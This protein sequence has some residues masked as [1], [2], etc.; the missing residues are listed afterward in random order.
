MIWYNLQLNIADFRSQF[1]SQIFLTFY[2]CIFDS[3]IHPSSFVSLSLL[4][5]C[6][7][8]ISSLWSLNQNRVSIFYSSL[9]CLFLLETSHSNHSLLDT[10]SLTWNFL[11]RSLEYI[12]LSVLP[13]HNCV[14]I[15]LERYDVPFPPIYF[16]YKT[17]CEFY[18]YSPK[19]S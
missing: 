18:L 13:T 15:D 12:S 2:L 8:T 7:N 17:S 6:T 5:C 3:F 10:D 4:S 11:R 1:N 9:L 19:N 16:F 14:W